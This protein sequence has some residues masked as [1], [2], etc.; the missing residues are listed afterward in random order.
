MTSDFETVLSTLDVSF[1]LPGQVPVN[2]LLK[3]VA[4][5]LHSLLTENGPILN[6]KTV[7][8]KIC[9]YIYFYMFSPCLP[10]F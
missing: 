8:Y 7:K 2:Q 1:I 4:H 9:V 3:F 6:V 10:K 5:S